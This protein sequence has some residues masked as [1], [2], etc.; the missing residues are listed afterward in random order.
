M[1]DD[2]DKQLSSMTA[3][4]LGLRL[5]GR[6]RA[7]L[8]AVA[9]TPL[10]ETDLGRLQVERAT[11]AP[12]IKRLRERHHAL[13]RAL[14][15]GMPNSEAAILCGYSDSRVSILLSDDAF[16]NLVN[17]YTNRVEEKFLE[18]PEKMNG[19]ATD[20]VDELSHRLEEDSDKFSNSQ[21]FEMAKI[22]ADR[23]GHGPTTKSEINV[24]IGLAE[25]LAAAR[26][27]VTSSIIDIT[28]NEAAE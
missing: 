2:L 23:T 15:T 24:K 16:C 5:N 7:P 22:F 6:G 21:L 27:R 13:A 19:L 17:H 1:T 20:A 26:K 12:P 9:G 4:D 25:R 11:K 14:S 18:L 28:P 3:A 8:T 10:T